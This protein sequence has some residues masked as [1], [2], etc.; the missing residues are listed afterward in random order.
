MYYEGI[1]LG[2]IFFSSISWFMPFV[3][4]ILIIIRNLSSNPAVVRMR[5][6]SIQGYR[7]RPAPG[8]GDIDLIIGRRGPIASAEMCN[9]LL[10]PIVAVD[11]IYSFDRDTLMK[12]IPRRKGESEDQF[13]K[14]SEALFNN[15]IQITDN[16]GAT[17]EHRAITYLAVRYDEIYNRTQLMQN[18][19]YSFTTIDVRPST[20]R[21]P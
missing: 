1:V 2:V 15:I 18:E 7:I 19:N 13:K 5:K 21:Y 4:T 6:R 11:Q 17:D 8:V 20:Q 14:T 3:Y 12:A 10:I 16:A 9:G